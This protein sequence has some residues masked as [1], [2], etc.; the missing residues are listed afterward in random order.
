MKHGPP[1][2]TLRSSFPA[3]ALPQ[4]ILGHG[5]IFLSGFVIVG[6]LYV[7][8]EEFV[9]EVW[10]DNLEASEVSSPLGAV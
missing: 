8:V 1:E 3:G 10:G 4:S 2:A 5:L 6:A 7:S 9:G